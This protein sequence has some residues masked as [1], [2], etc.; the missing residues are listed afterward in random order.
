VVRRI[1]G[2]RGD[3]RRTG[4]A[5]FPQWLSRVGDVIVYTVHTSVS[6]A[7][8]EQSDGVAAGAVLGV[9]VEDG[10][11]AGAHTGTRFSFLVRPRVRAVFP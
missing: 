4:E 8:A 3:Y 11:R 2:A 7:G 9:Q 10:G 1:Y 5:V 6:G